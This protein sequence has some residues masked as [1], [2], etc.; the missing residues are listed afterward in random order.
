M[1]EKYFFITNKSTMLSINCTFYRLTA[2][3]RMI[4]NKGSTLK[5]P[6][7][8]PPYVK[9]PLILNIGYH[10][11]HEKGGIDPPSY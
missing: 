8:L 10:I 2:L 5:T 6:R 4:P 7:P 11:K 1:A 9:H 3:F